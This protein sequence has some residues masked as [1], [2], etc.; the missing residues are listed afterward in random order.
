MAINNAE[1]YQAA[2]LYKL[3]VQEM[4]TNLIPYGYSIPVFDINNINT[5]IY[6]TV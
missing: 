3:V 1:L 6:E 4:N 5:T 2:A